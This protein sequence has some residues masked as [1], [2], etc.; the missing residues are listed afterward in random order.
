MEWLNYHHLLY[1]YVVAREGSIT[2]ASAELRVSQPTI[3]AQLRT[4][5]E[6][7]SNKLFNRVG[8]RLELTENGRAVYSYAEEIFSLG[9]EL[10]GVVRGRSAE[11]PLRLTVGVTD[12]LPK[13]IVY[14]LLKPVFSIKDIRLVC[15]E[16]KYDRLLADL[17]IHTLDLVLAD[18]PASPSIKVKA[19]NSPL[20]ESGVTFLGTKDFVTKCRK[21]FPKSLNGVP[22]L[23]PSAGTAL[24]RALEQW[25]NTEKIMPSIRG[26]FQD[27]A[28]VEAFGKSG[29]GVFAMPTA[30]ET[31]VVDQ[32][33]VNVIGRVSSVRT[34]FYAISV[35]RRL[36]HPGVVAI[37]DSA[38]N[39]LFL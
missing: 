37:C 15:V 24:R 9:R 35:E 22:M 39:N 13:L 31:E 29:A 4:L 2:K 30:I 14:R 25:F 28:L 20:G 7:M 36:K 33:G 12:V 1:F 6:S 19:F 21:G 3:S 17:A 27:S 5:E 18:T 32:F 11:R 16:D 38:R 23:L 34:R 26:E 8:R 10:M